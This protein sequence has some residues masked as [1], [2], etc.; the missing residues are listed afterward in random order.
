MFVV[1]TETWHEDGG[2]IWANAECFPA[3]HEAN[4]DKLL[5]E[6]NL[7]GNTKL[8]GSYNFSFLT[9]KEIKSIV[10]HYASWAMPLTD[11]KRGDWGL[12]AVDALKHA[13]VK[14]I[15]EIIYATR[16]TN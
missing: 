14:K 7:I 12:L 3:S 15:K 8:I 11:W 6:L 5:S 9:E 10:S 2:E 16:G 4:I 13:N 1:I